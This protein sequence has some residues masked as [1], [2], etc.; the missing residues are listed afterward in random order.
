MKSPVQDESTCD[1]PVPIRPFVSRDQESEV[2]QGSNR[3]Q[4]KPVRKFS[5]LFQCE[6]MKIYDF[7]PSYNES[8]F[9]S[10]KPNPILPFRDLLLVV[11]LSKKW[12]QTSCKKRPLRCEGRQ[13]KGCGEGRKSFFKLVTFFEKRL[14]LW[15][16]DEKHYVSNAPCPQNVN[17]RQ[18][19][20]CSID[21]CKSCI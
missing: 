14:F 20:F 10:R 8:R 2:G 15:S 6:M 13:I 16:S 11:S 1:L 18:T 7:W 17:Q 12:C 19:F 9:C 4:Q 21:D 3:M 5:Q